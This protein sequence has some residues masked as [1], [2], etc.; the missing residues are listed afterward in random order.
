MGIAARRTGR[1]FG[2]ALHG[3]PGIEIR[4]VASLAGARR[5]RAR[6]ASLPQPRLRPLAA[7][8][9]A[10]AL[11]LS[12]QDD[13]AWRAAT[14]ARASSPPTPTPTSPAPRKHC[15]QALTA[16]ASRPPASIRGRRCTG[17][18]VDPSARIGPLVT[19]EAGAV[20][21]AGAVID[22]GCYIGAATPGRRGHAISS[23]T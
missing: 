7:H 8:S 1:T 16:S 2:G 15:W 14:A 11:I 17:A 5:A 18:R 3:D 23:P 19:V 22:A 13:A 12:P 9:R 4:S 20:V 21:A 6:S 10:A